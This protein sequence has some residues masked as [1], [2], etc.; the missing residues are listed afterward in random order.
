MDAI[1]DIN[2]GAGYS[3]SERLSLAF[4]ARNL[5]CRKAETIPGLPGQGLQALLSATYRF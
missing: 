5:L 1:C 3:L 2:I 4:D